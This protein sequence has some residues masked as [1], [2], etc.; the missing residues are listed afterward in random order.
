MQ[1]RTAT[2][3]DVLEI[4]QFQVNMARETEGIK[5]E[6][7]TV[8]EG[9]QAVIEDA[10]KGTYYLAEVR[11]ELAGMLLTTYEWSDWRNGRILWIQSVYVHKKYRKQGVYKQLY[12]HIQKLVKIHEND[13][14][15]IRLYVDKSNLAAISVYQKLG[16]QDHH[17]AM[18]E[19]MNE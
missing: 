7:A 1:I 14:R 19:W 5:L 18:Y 13:F 6:E 10:D 17:Y 9:V 11:G 8:Q 4:S 16:M 12:Q 3:D 15:G 2:K